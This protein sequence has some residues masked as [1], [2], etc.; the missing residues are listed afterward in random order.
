VSSRYVP[1]AGR[2]ALT[3]VYD[4]VLHLTMRESSWRPAVASLAGGGYVVEVGAGTGEQT[5]LL[6]RSSGGAGQV[7]AVDGDPAVLSVARAK[8]GA[9][10]VRFVEGLA[11][12]LPVESGAADAVVMTLL[13]HHLDGEGKRAALREAARVLRP[14]GRL[15]VADWGP[16][17]GLVPSLG[18]R[19]LTAIDGAAG[20]SDHGAGRLP[21]FITSAGFD[22]PRLHGRI[23][24][25]WGTLELL[26][27]E[28]RG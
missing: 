1:A 3:Q 25:V 2:A 13:L 26:T 21:D 22:R 28:R 9:E 4:P 15:V 7:V 10:G 18:F 12:A 11:D 23:A 8:P 14:D 19:L 24:T 20:T 27:A 6:A 17:R 5:L 16:P